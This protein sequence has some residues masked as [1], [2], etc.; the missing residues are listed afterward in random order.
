VIEG[1]SLD[2][3]T[4]G[5]AE[6]VLSGRLILFRGMG[7]AFRLKFFGHN[8]TFQFN[9]R[10]G[11]AIEM[12]ARNLSGYSH[13]DVKG[14]GPSWSGSGSKEPMRIGDLRFEDGR[15]AFLMLNFLLFQ[16]SIEAPVTIDYTV[17]AV[18]EADAARLGYAPLEN[19]PSSEG[20]E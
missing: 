1:L 11:K 13:I 14:F 15:K 18:W 4:S 3:I 5:P 8:H 7:T 6:I 16:T 17:Y 20:A 19:K 12:S 9:F 2:K 10:D